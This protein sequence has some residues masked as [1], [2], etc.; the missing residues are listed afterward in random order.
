[1]DEIYITDSIFVS[2]FYNLPKS[3]S[4]ILLEIIRNINPIIY[5]SY[6]KNDSVDKYSQES[7]DKWITFLQALFSNSQISS[8]AKD[9]DYLINKAIESMFLRDKQCK[10]CNNRFLFLSNKIE[11]DYVHSE[12]INFM[13]SCFKFHSFKHYSLSVPETETFDVL[14]DLFTVYINDKIEK[15]RLV[16][17]LCNIA[18][19]SM[20]NLISRYTIGESCDR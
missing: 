19:K 13:Y 16:S 6:I 8:V 9:I 2:E 14:Y 3:T 20:V 1:M 12:Y 4:C 15:E 10:E 11:P 5:N 7:I 17:V 18:E